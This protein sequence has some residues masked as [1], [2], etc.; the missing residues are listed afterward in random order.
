MTRRTRLG[1][2][3][4]PSLS[5]RAQQAVALAIIFAIAAVAMIP[6]IAVYFGG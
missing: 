4:A 6:G 1:T 2:E 3:H 5:P